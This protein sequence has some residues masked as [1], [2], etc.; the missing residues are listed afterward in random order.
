MGK[1]IL[2]IV[3]DIESANGIC[4]QN[5]AKKLIEKQWDVII[6]TQDGSET[7]DHGVMKGLKWETVSRHW[8][9]K[10]K[11][12][13]GKAEWKVKQF[14]KR[15]QILLLSPAWPLYA[16]GLSF[17]MCKAAL[18]IVKN[19]H[20]DA[21]VPVY[22][23]IDALIAGC[24]VKKMRKELLLV[25]YY[26]DSLI[27]GQ[28][29]SF[30]TESKRF[31]KACN[32]EKKV[33]EYAD[34]AIMMNSARR[35]YSML[36]SKPEYLKKII[37]L[38]LP[39]LQ[40]DEGDGGAGDVGA[41][42]EPGKLNFLFMGSMPRNIRS[43][44]KLLQIFSEIQNANCRLYLVG[45]TDYESEIIDAIQKDHRIKYIGPVSHNDARQYMREANFLI[46]LGNTLPYMV[47]S[48]IFEYMSMCKPIISVKAIT[49]DP[50]DEYLKKYPYSLIID[51]VQNAAFRIQ[52]F[53]DYCSRKSK[54]EIQDEVERLTCKNGDLYRNTPDAFLMTLEKG[55]RNG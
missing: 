3:T 5:V 13:C 50:S 24:Y 23:S 42:L 8:S 53:M 12:C 25:P 38:D 33:M 45:M 7:T 14:F 27:G 17:R 6:L 37:F 55:M 20:V 32:V 34:F 31:K 44:L 2:F 52:E 4:V 36:S 22:N 54:K 29:P 18:S 16:P 21:V 51:S 35:K 46:N 9:N 26:L 11:S 43:P 48:K 40:M 19:N 10:Q 30:M 49:D 47:P 28:C 1:T 41:K 39:M 15:V